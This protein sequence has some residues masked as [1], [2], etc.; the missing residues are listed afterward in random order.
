MIEPGSD[1][2][3]Y[4]LWYF[5]ICFDDAPFSTFHIIFSDDSVSFPEAV[6]TMIIYIVAIYKIEYTQVVIYI[7][8]LV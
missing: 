8:G 5:H 2:F 3:E 1:D 6:S 7:N 4:L